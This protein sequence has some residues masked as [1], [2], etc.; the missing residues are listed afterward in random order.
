LFDEPLSNLDAG[1]RAQMRDE[2]RSLQKKLG[3]TTVYVTHD[4]EEAMAISDRI[5]VM[6]KGMIVQ[7]GGSEELYRQPASVFV[8]RFIGHANLLP[9][10]VTAISARDVGI[11][12]A[13]Q[14]LTIP[15]QKSDLRPG[16][17]MIAVIRP[18]A[19]ATFGAGNTEAGLIGRIISCTY[20][21]DKCEYEVELP[22]MRVRV[23]KANPRPSDR[24]TP[25]TV[26]CVQLPADG[27]HLL[28]ES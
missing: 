26:V 27:I 16:Q 24:L 5:A 8:A 4:Q 1:L 18:E 15:G 20:L 3:I 14:F 25:A 23:T 9:A 28:P 19:L 10:T 12:I 21:G 6:N 17:S 13:G 22:G 7:V 2:I 11:K